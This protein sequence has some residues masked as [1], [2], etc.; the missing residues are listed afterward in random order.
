[1]PRIRMEP[2][3]RKSNRIGA[4]PKD[5]LRNRVKQPTETFRLPQQQEPI[6]AIVNK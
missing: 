3:V 2:A 4:Y 5:M 6:P 1:M